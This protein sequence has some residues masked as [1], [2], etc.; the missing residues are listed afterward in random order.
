[1]KY[2][3]DLRPGRNPKGCVHVGKWNIVELSMV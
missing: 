1:M 2:L 3:G